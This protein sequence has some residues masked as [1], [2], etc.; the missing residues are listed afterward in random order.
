MQNR[1]QGARRLNID[2]REQIKQ[3][4]LAFKDRYEYRARGN[5]ERIFPLPDEDLEKSSKHGD[6][7]QEYDF[8]VACS[9]EVWGEATT[10][11]GVNAKKRID[12]LEKKLR[13]PQQT[14]QKSKEKET[15]LSGIKAKINSMPSSDRKPQH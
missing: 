8:L 7:Q 2:E 11:G 10:G 5:Y 9:K 15:P 1:L 6:L 3:K 4:K 14:P 12:E 13:T